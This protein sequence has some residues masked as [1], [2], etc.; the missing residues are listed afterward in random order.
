MLVCW[1]AIFYKESFAKYF[2]IGVP[3]ILGVFFY[4]FLFLFIDANLNPVYFDTL[5]MVL[6]SI[7]ISAAIFF[8]FSF[9]VWKLKSSLKYGF[10]ITATVLFIILL[11]YN[12]YS[13]TLTFTEYFLIL[14]PW[15]ISAVLINCIW[16]SYYFKQQAL[17]FY[18]IAL[19]GLFFLFMLISLS[20]LFPT[21]E[22]DIRIL[23][24]IFTSA[25]ASFF[26]FSICARYFNI[27]TQKIIA[28]TL[29]ISVIS[30]FNSKNINT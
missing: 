27:L 14:L 4:R 30:V 23:T 5:Y 17:S 28:T 3:V 13:L 12:F 20:F 8:I 26:I 7:V 11:I 24:S 25:G 22:L 21:L 1:R 6:Y 15:L 18:L 9:T 16:L 10:I 2:I 29:G 19:G